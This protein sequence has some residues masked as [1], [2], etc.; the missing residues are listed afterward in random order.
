M[1]I[2]KRSH[3]AQNQQVFFLFYKIQHFD[4]RKHLF[5]RYLGINLYLLCSSVCSAAA[6][7]KHEDTELQP[8]TTSNRQT[9]NTVTSLY[10]TQVIFHLKHTCHLSLCRVWGLRGSV[11]AGGNNPLCLSGPTELEGETRQDSTGSEPPPRHLLFCHHQTWRQI[12]S[13]Q[14]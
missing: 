4:V 9:G 12:E 3:Q 11:S 1:V 7:Q 5:T 10:C 14:I 8:W 13:Q 6:S 2:L